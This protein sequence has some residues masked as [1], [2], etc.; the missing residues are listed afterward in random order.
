[1]SALLCARASRTVATD[2]NVAA[3]SV[4][5]SNGSI[6]EQLLQR[7]EPKTAHLIAE[8]GVDLTPWFIPKGY[9]LHTGAQLD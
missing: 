1:M 2:G 8:Q 7:M 9:R 5:V 3:C 6:H 4:V